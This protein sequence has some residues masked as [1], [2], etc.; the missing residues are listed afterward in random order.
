MICIL[1]FQGKLLPWLQSN[2][3]HD[4]ETYSVPKD[5]VTGKPSSYLLC[6][7]G[8]GP[9][10]DRRWQMSSAPDRLFLKFI[11]TLKFVFLC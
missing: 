6:L 4:D 1:L 7:Q 3:R 5:D 10:D 9:T 8:I 11:L 2:A